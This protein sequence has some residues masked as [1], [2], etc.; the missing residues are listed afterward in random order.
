[1]P[2]NLL[3]PGMSAD[4]T[5]LLRIKP[6]ATAPRPTGA[7]YFK[8]LVLDEW[9]EG[10]Q[11]VRGWKLVY[12]QDAWSTMPAGWYGRDCGD[13]RHPIGWVL[14]TESLPL[15]PDAAIPT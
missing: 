13:L 1:M 12:W 8:L 6:M 7:E 5:Q 3:P 10:G 11:Q 15:W 4:A 14:S 9:D 2:D